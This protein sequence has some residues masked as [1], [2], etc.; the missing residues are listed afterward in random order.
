M[1]ISAAAL[2]G[3]AFG[4]AVSQQSFASP[5]EFINVDRL[6]GDFN[7]GSPGN[8][9]VVP[10]YN[11]VDLDHD[12]YPDRLRVWLDTYTAGTNTQLYSSA[13]R[14]YLTP[15]LPAGCDPEEAF[16]NLSF[17]PQVT[18]SGSDPR[19]TVYLGL[20]MWCFNGAEAVGQQNTIVY[21]ASVAEAGGD[22]WKYFT[23]DHELW[24]F[25]EIDP[26][27]DSTN[28]AIYLLFGTDVPRGAN[29]TVLLLDKATGTVLSSNAYPV[30]R[31]R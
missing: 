8:E 24:G 15:T 25:G 28:D 29:G 18:R 31:V 4:A 16:E 14:A 2:I 11:L 21:S 22:A 7:A 5:E 30:V 10:V 23:A 6:Y 20:N 13:V 12:G 19:V 26:D 9:V 27:G 17:E 1:R 3:I